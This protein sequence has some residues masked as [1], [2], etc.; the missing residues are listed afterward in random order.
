M[1]HQKG[2]NADDSNSNSSFAIIDDENGQNA[3]NN[4]AL[5]EVNVFILFKF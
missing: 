5:L 1:N 2:M 4:I 3:K